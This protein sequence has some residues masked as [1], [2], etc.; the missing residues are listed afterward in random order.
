MEASSI[1]FY[2]R[3][4]RFDG[5]S[6]NSN[7]R[8]DAGGLNDWHARRDGWRRIIPLRQNYVVVAPRVT[9]KSNEAWFVSRTVP[10]SAGGFT[11]KHR[12][13]QQFTFSSEIRLLSW[14]IPGIIQ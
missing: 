11:A 1:D 12:F 3:F 2:Q 6:R 7:F 14:D 5:S 9:E 4:L 8:D 10:E 13:S